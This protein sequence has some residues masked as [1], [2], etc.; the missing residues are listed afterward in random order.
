MPGADVKIGLATLDEDGEVSG[1]AAQAGHAG[2]CSCGFVTSGWPT[3]KAATERIK[4]HRGEHRGE[5]EMEDLAEFRARHGIGVNENG[6]AVSL[7]EN[8]QEV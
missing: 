5:G 8:V 3:K 4:Q 6:R 2:V 1:H 7:P